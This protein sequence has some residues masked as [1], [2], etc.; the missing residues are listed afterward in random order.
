MWSSKSLMSLIKSSPLHNVELARFEGTDISDKEIMRSLQSHLRINADA[1]IRVALRLSYC[2]SRADK[3][4]SLGGG[5]D[6]WRG[7]RNALLRVG[8]MESTIPRGIS[9]IMRT[10][11]LPTLHEDKQKQLKASRR[12][13]AHTHIYVYI[14]R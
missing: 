12:H 14:P 7:T 1:C 4:V 11:T 2:F 9:L 3:S 6:V 10:L 13:I 5:G 8:L